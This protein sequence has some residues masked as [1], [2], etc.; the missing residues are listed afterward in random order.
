[1]ITA[2]VKQLKDELKNKEQAELVELC[3]SLAKFKKENKELLT[4][5]LFEASD[6]EEFVLQVKQEISQAFGEINASNLYFVKKSARKILRT[7]KR[8]I[9]YSKN[10]TTEADLLIHFCAKLK[11]IRPSVTA[12]SQ[13][14]NLLDQQLKMARKAVST[15]HEDLQYDYQLILESL[16]DY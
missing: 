16:S 5:L 3:L 10:K 13:L 7:V 14:K 8:Y 11:G 1:M 15:L 12:S 9:R 4:Y 6:E 2:S